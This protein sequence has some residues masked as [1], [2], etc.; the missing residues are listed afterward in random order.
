MVE[1]CLVGVFS[2]MLDEQRVA[3]KASFDD[4][5]LSVSDRAASRASIQDRIKRVYV[6]RRRW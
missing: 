2:T 4:V 1:R 5:G 3:L 6:E